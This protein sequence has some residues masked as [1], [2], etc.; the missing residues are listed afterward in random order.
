MSINL[1]GSKVKKRNITG[2]GLG[3]LASNL[4]CST[5]NYG[6]IGI[7]L[8]FLS[9]LHYSTA[10]QSEA[11]LALRNTVFCILKS[12]FPAILFI[13]VFIILKTFSFL[14]SFMHS[15]ILHDV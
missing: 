2:L 8:T 11:F 7:H 1:F 5:N 14:K 4:S 10:I 15:G 13:T 3:N 6:M 12:F 9:L